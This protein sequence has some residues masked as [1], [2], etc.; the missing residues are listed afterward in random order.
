MFLQTYEYVEKFCKINDKYIIDELRIFLEDLG[1]ND[2]ENA[3][4]INLLPKN[5]EEAR[6]L[7]PSLEK[8]PNT[9]LENIVFKIRELIYS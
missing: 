7:I 2:E 9:I 3:S 8:Y 1:I 6:L 5:I 4:V